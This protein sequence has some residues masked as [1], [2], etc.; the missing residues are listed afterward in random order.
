VVVCAYGIMGAASCPGHDDDRN[1]AALGT[2]SCPGQGDD[3][4]IIA[5][6][7]SIMFCTR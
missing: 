7:G 2:V 1:I 6:R 5:F 3:S 4:N